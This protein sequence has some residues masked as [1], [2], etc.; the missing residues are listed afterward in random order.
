MENVFVAK[1]RDILGFAYIV[2]ETLKEIRFK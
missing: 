2:K 1:N